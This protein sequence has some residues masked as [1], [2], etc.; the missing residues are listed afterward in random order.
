[1]MG[2]FTWDRSRGR[3]EEGSS[4]LAE[5]DSGCRVGAAMRGSTSRSRRCTEAEDLRKKN[6]ENKLSRRVNI[7]LSPT[8]SY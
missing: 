3:E 8:L 5:A 1:M 2:G 7:F 4:W 6:E